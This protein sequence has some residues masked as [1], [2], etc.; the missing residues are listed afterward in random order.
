MKDKII[1][2]LFIGYIFVFAILHIIIPDKEISNTERRKLTVFPKFELNSEY[3]TKVDKYLLD[4]FP[5]RDDLRS[6]KAIYNYKFLNKLDNNGIF[7]KDGAIYKSTY[8]TNKKSISNF[9]KHLETL[10]GFLSE[11]N[12]I[13]MM[14]IPDKN[15]YLDE[16]DFLH[17]DYDYIYSEMDK[18]NINKIDI[19]DILNL[20]DYYKTDTHWRQEN[21]D[22]V[23]YKMS[24]VMGF[25]Y[26]NLKYNENTHNDFYGVYYG[27][28]ALK[29]S[30]D[31]LTYL[32]NDLID[33]VEVK[34][35]E[36]TNLNKVYNVDKL[37]GVDPYEIYLDGASS[38][39]E[40]INKES[41]SD[42][43]LVIFRDSFA[44][45]ISPLLINYYSKITLIDNR[46]ISSNVFNQ[47]I[48]FKNQDV[49]F[50]YST[51]II[52]NSGSLKN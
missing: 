39:I 7:I 28:S 36:N 41:K 48:E 20:N 51:L 1:T 27:E 47:M 13:Y 8:P 30:G 26:K 40:I 32:S 43:E 24:S 10:K 16:E 37:G 34:Y 42:K 25:D 18:I 52:N 35:L 4:H 44:S 31:I 23:V 49:I 6:V 33:K 46:Y 22:K 12:N 9:V 3:I 11:E 50:M 14:I 2:F 21:L 38:Y 19:K 15:Y 17:I 5:F 45:S 29:T